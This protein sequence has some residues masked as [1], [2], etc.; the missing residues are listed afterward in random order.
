MGTPFDFFGPKSHTAN[1]SIST[2]ARKNR[3]ILKGA[4]EKQG[5][6]NYRKEW[7]HYTFKPE[8][9]PKTYFNFDVIADRKK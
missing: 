3:L 4:M 5:F 9:T 6:E 1:Q 8:P 2:Q 7:W